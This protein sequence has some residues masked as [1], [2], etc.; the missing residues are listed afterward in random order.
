MIKGKNLLAMVIGQMPT[1]RDLVWYVPVVDN[2]LGHVSILFLTVGY[3]QVILLLLR[4][5]LVIPDKLTPRS[6]AK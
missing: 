5:R 3:F 6:G 1:F 4:F 2:Q